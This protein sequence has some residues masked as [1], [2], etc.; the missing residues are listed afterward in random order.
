MAPSTESSCAFRNASRSIRANARVFIPALFVGRLPEYQ[1]FGPHC[2][3]KHSNRPSS[4]PPASSRHSLR[5]NNVSYRRTIPANAKILR[6]VRALSPH[7]CCP[8]IPKLCRKVG[9]A[10]ASR[11]PTVQ[12]TITQSYA[13]KH[14]VGT[15]TLLDEGCPLHRRNCPWADDCEIVRNH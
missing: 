8:V 4:S 13:P 5:S 7:H 15:K 14:R 6:F 3:S 2:P 11:I 12:L 9:G 10:I 1:K